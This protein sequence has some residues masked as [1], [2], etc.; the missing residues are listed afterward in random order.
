[1]KFNHLNW[2]H[3]ISSHGQPECVFFFYSYIFVNRF[4]EQVGGLELIVSILGWW[5]SRFKFLRLQKNHRSIAGI[6]MDNI[7]EI[8]EIFI[9]SYPSMIPMDNMNGTYYGYPFWSNKISEA[10]EIMDMTRAP[11][12]QRHVIPWYQASLTFSTLEG[13]E[14]D[15]EESYTS[16][17]H[18]SNLCSLRMMKRRV[19]ITCLGVFSS[20][21][22]ELICLTCHPKNQERLCWRSDHH[23]DGCI[24]SVGCSSGV[25]SGPLVCP[26][27]FIRCE[28]L[29]RMC[30]P[31]LVFMYM[32]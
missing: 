14:S 29:Q 7:M 2:G 27:G 5:S 20:A 17:T 25:A 1:M 32:L 3:P 10:E 19:Q 12:R 6:I 4:D 26:I 8:T 24:F 18:K 31:A 21:H 22:L 11:R 30:F 9:Q 23:C 15:R 13:A 28:Q 16:Y